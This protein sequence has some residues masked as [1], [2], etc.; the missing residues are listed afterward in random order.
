[1]S[2]IPAKYYYNR[3]KKQK[4]NHERITYIYI[5]T[6]FDVT[7]YKK[8]IRALSL[9]V[10]CKIGTSYPTIFFC[11]PQQHWERRLQFKRIV[12]GNNEQTKR[13]SEG[14]QISIN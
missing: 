12:L 6:I 5:C 10:Y 8:T 7:Q 4:T 11:Q 14:Y 9:Y 1:M 3:H 2:F 13:E